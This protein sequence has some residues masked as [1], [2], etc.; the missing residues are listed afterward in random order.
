[1]T[2]PV[3]WLVI[4]VGDI[5]TK[6]VLPAILTEPRSR[7]V[8]IVTRTPAK[9]EAFGVPGWVDLEPALK[10]S[11]ADAVY[12]GSPVAL[13]APQTITSLRA[14][15]HV[16][17]E[18]PVA[19]NY[20]EACTMRDAAEWSERILGIAYYRRTYPKLLRARQL[21]QDGVIGQPVYA[22]I[23]CHSGPPPQSGPRSW[24]VD[25]AI[26]GGGP[27]Y[28]IASHRID[29]LNFLFGAP[30]R[31]VGQMSNVVHQLEVE[32][33]ATVLIEYESGM[34]GVVDVRWHTHQDRDDFRIIGTDGEMQLSPLNGPRLAYKGREEQLP[35]HKNLHYPCIEDF[36]TAV[37]E[38]KLPAAPIGEAIVTDWVTEQVMRQNGRG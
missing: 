5:T 32:D 21:L 4:G 18:K 14:G 17:C 16:L 23:N 28:D 35:T 22:E 27:L 36:T 31:V 11:D 38:G 6:R 20:V 7:L 29:V 13:H 26:A 15:K 19:L 37:L 1:M 12:V 25:P 24:F 9:A 3:K 30:G 10:E 34:R 8:G 2:E 33:S